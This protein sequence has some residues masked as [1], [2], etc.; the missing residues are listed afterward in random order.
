MS[1]NRERFVRLAEPRVNKAVNELRLVGN[2][3]NRHNY[4]FTEEEG[5]TIINALKASVSAVESRFRDATRSQF[6][7]FKLRRED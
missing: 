5:R 4:D 7:E 3:F 6:A 2:L 1:P